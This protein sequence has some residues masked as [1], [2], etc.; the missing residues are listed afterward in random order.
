MHKLLFN[1]ICVFIYSN[2][3]KNKVYEPTFLYISYRTRA[4]ICSGI[5]IRILYKTG[6]CHP[7]YV[8]AI[9]RLSTLCYLLAHKY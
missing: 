5:Q 6:V 7:G 1:L 4:S 3:Q 2:T 9:G 8:I